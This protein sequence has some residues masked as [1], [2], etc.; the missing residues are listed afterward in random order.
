MKYSST[1]TYCSDNGV[2]AHLLC[3]ICVFWCSDI[4]CHSLGIFHV[5]NVKIKFMQVLLFLLRV[6][7]AS[8]FYLQIILMYVLAKF[9]YI[10]LQ[11]SSR[12]SS[13]EA[14]FSARNSPKN[15]LAAGHRQD[16][17]GELTLA[18]PDPLAGFREWGP[19]NRRGG[20]RRGIEWMRPQLQQRGC[21]PSVHP[22]L[23]TLRYRHYEAEKRTLRRMQTL[24]WTTCL[25]DAS[26]AYFATET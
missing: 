20:E 6:V 4:N 26:G 24:V 8:I 15:R 7:G 10:W 13:P 1:R 19:V 2:W 21:A 22:T 17:Q 12:S 11:T 9:A 16:P 5:W 25:P 18:L 3:N 23:K 14:W